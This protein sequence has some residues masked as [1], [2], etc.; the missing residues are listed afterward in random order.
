[1]TVERSKI[2]LIGGKR[3]V[4]VESDSQ[5]EQRVAGGRAFELRGVAVR[6][7]A[8]SKILEFFSV[9]SFSFGSSSLGFGQVPFAIPRRGGVSGRTAP[10]REE[11]AKRG[12]YSM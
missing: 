10:G 1:M 2:F 4:F 3:G 9:D 12:V 6:K 11:A 7:G 5:A 8:E